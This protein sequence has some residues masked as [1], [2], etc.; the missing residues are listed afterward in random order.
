MGA[1]TPARGASKFDTLPHFTGDAWQG[2][3]KVPDP[4]LGWVTLWSHG[5]HA[6]DGASHAAIRRWTAPADGRVTLDGQLKHER[7]EGDGVRPP[8]SS[9]AAGANSRVGPSTT[10]ARRRSS[11]TSR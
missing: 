1:T 9:P 6:G 11:T 3:P 5:G 2:G 8:A 7:A 10:A 4:K